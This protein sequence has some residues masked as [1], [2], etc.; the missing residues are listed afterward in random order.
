MHAFLKSKPKVSTEKETLTDDDEDGTGRIKVRGKIYAFITWIL[1][2][3]HHDSIFSGVDNKGFVASPTDPRE[4][5]TVTDERKEKK[6]E[7]VVEKESK[8]EAKDEKK[9]EEKE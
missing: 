6:K 7:P 5:V 3:S 2:K 1:I 4:K 9:E 8:D